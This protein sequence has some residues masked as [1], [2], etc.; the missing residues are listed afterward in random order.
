VGRRNAAIVTAVALAALAAV[1]AFS[2]MSAPTPGASPSPSVA[3]QTASPSATIRPPSPTAT[4]QAGA[5]TGRLGYPSEFI[6]PL[7]VYAISTTDQRV[8]FSVDVPRYPPASPATPL[9]QGTFRPGEEPRYTIT[10]VAPGTYYVLAYRNDGQTPDP[11]AYTRA[12]QAAI[13]YCRPGAPPAPC[14]DHSLVPVTVAAGQ[15]VSGI[16]VTDWT[17]GFVQPSP[18]IPPR[19]TSR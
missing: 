18:T 17:V 12:A 10:G 5:I 3:A 8:W 6:P 11:G 15:T 19:P 13:L 14:D 1:L 7:T 2:V 16:D 9:P 4:S